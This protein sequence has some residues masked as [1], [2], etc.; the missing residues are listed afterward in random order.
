MQK[1][2]KLVFGSFLDRDFIGWARVS[3]SYSNLKNGDNWD[4]GNNTDGNGKLME[5]NNRNNNFFSSCIQ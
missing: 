3:N 5:G 4:N 2:K 1:L